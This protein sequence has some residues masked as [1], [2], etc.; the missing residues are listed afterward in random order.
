[1]EIDVREVRRY[2]GYKKNKIDSN[3]TMESDASVHQL[4]LQCIEELNRVATPRFVYEILPLTVENNEVDM[5]FLHVTSKNLS[6]NLHDCKMVAVM[7]ATIG[8]E[9]DRLINRYARLN[10]AKAVIMQAA[11]VAMIESWCDECQEQ[12]REEA[13]K[14]GLFLRPRFSPGYGDFSLE[15]QKSILQVLQAP[16]KIGLTITDSFLMVPMKSVTAVI[17]LSEYNNNCEKSGCEVCKK[18]NCAYRR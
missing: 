14:K 3:E 7:A 10:V 1:M 2:L 4:I 9:V 11:A 5:V 8:T 15:S 6:K 18:E 13:N 12:I 17:G 16:K